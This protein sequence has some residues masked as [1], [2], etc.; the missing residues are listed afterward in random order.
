[1]MK[2]RLFHIGNDRIYVYI[3]ESLLESILG[4][5]F[6][7]IGDNE[8]MLIRFPEFKVN[9]IHMMFV[10]F[11]IDVFWLDD[12]FKIVNVNKGV[13]PFSLYTSSNVRAKYALETRTGIING[14]LSGKVVKFK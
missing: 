12:K 5:M 6:R 3:C 8:G 11:S 9:A 7:N 1:M 2:R 10:F 14:N 13:K 4:L